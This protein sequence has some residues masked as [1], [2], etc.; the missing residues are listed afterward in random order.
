MSQHTR[1]ICSQNRGN[2]D[3]ESSPF[4][5][6][7]AWAYCQSREGSRTSSD[8]LNPGGMRMAESRERRSV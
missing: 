8:A 3:G 7:E 1:S 5:R 6:V 2:V 4:H